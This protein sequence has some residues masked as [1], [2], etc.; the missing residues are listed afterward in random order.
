MSG[1]VGIVN[2]DGAPVNRLL[3][4]EMIDHQAFRG[5][6]AQS[7]WIE[8]NVG[9]GHT[10][11]RTTWESEHEHQ[12]SSLDG[13][14]WITADARVDDRE[15]LVEKLKSKGQEVASAAPDAELILHAYHVWGE[16]S[17]EHLLGDFA[18][19]I[20]DGRL[21][22]VFCARD[23]LG[24]KPF[25]YFQ[26]GKAFVFSNTLN[27]VR[28]HPDVSGK[29]N[30]LAVA[31]FLLFSLNQNAA[32]TIF[33][34]I[35]RIGPAHSLTV[36]KDDCVMRRYWSMP[37]DEPV[38]YRHNSD[39]V[40]R[41]NELLTLAVRD[42]T[43]TPWIGVFMSG[44]LDSSALAA[45]ACQLLDRRPAVEAFTSVFDHLIPDQER[46][47]AALVGDRLGI[48]IHYNACDDKIVDPDWSGRPFRT[49]EPSLG[50]I[51]RA[52]KLDE[53][54]SFAEHGRVFFYGEGP[55]NAL[56]YEWQPYLHY[57]AR[58]HRWSRLIRDI[59]GHV[60]AH[61]RVLPTSTILSYGKRVAGAEPEPRFP[62]WLDEEFAARTDARAR[63]ETM[64]SPTDSPHPVRPAGFQSFASPQWQ[65]VFESIDPG[66][67]E[68][69][70]EFRH[71]YVDLRLLRYMLSVPSLP[72]CRRKHLMRRAMRNM[73]PEEVLRRDKA[74][75]LGA[76]VFQ[77]VRRSGMPPL[78]PTGELWKY[79]D[80][81]QVPCTMPSDASEFWMNL[82]PAVLNH[83]LGR[84][85]AA[86]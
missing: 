6:D 45:T 25:Y 7:M 47:Y 11:L 21:R 85:N 4:K 60:I 38:Y 56:K 5:P 28:R 84:S 59:F 32:T 43:R 83:W 66:F 30:D 44:G 40:D 58:G 13:Q 52:Q 68:A 39:Y 77:T 37:I 31:D 80:P 50:S 14:V 16:Q 54:R 70:I 12:P 24:I 72:W 1:I 23:H 19:A 18:F 15:N 86:N 53:F 69:P 57:L 9:F 75:L 3:L 61:K 17:V 73:L 76:P 27:C 71:P 46:Y 78:V 42:R 67:T 29:L 41:F 82:R 81:H 35:Q 65:R 48:P 79:I 26:S 10:M 74:P 49:P 36:S 62:A 34:D 2:L 63:W 22:R 8:G 20:W 33:S 64:R 51:N 55:D